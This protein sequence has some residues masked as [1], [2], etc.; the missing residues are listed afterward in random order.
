[1]SKTLNE[2]EWSQY[3]CEDLLPILSLLRQRHGAQVYE[4]IHD[5]KGI[6]T[7]VYLE[8]KIPG[9]AMEEIMMGFS[10]NENLRFGHGSVAC[11]RDYCSIGQKESREKGRER[12]ALSRLRD[13]VL[14]VFE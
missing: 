6:Y 7:D 10:S 3:I 4:V 5:L 13:F 9:K 14:R 8:E 11:V 2:S 12:S 1:M